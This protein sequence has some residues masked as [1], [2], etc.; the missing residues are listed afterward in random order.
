[1][2]FKDIESFMRLTPTIAELNKCNSKFYN[3][4]NQLKNWSYCPN[5]LNILFMSR[6]EL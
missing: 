5:Y 2:D 3:I 4:I 6:F 1:M